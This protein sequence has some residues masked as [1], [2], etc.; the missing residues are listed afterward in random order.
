MYSTLIEELERTY[1]FDKVALCKETVQLWY[2]LKIDYKKIK[3]N[4]V[5]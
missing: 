3:C 4:C 2:A 5:W 1:I